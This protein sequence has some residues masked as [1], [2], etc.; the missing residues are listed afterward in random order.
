MEFRF[1]PPKLPLQNNLLASL[2][3]E[4]FSIFSHIVSRFQQSFRVSGPNAHT[5]APFLTRKKKVKNL[6]HI[7][8]EATKG[9]YALL[10][11]QRS[12]H[13]QPENRPEV[14]TNRP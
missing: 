12:Q 11:T 4:L 7:R 5:P 10:E 2:F 13:S 14:A 3:V 8:G 1:A 9:V 6:Y